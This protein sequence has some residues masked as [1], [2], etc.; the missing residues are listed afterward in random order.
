VDAQV[1]ATF[2]VRGA[3]IAEPKQ[4]GPLMRAID[5]YM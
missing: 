2:D 5:G 4:V 1:S 3:L